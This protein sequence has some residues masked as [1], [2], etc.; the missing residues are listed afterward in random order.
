MTILVYLDYDVDRKVVRK[1]SLS[2]ARVGLELSQRLNTSLEGVVVNC[3][4]VVKQVA[5]LGIF[6]KIYDVKIEGLGE[7]VY[8][9]LVYANALVELC[10]RH[11]VEV[12]LFPSTLKSREIAPYVAAKL[13]TGIVADVSKL[14]VDE[15]GEVISVKPSFG[16]NILAH[17]SIPGRKPKIFT[18]RTYLEEVPQGRDKTHIETLVISLKQTP[19]LRTRSVTVED[20]DT[21]I[22]PE[23]SDIVIGIGAGVLPEN[24]KLLK[25]I[26]RRLK[27]SI[28]A[29]KKVTDRGILPDKFLVGESGKLIRPKL[30]IAL[31]ISGAPQHMTGVKESK[32]I[33]AVN[34]TDKAPIARQCDYFIR[35]DANEVIRLL[36]QRILT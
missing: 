21:A 31:G 33:V 1:E 15:K 26:A 35:A 18:V 23:R 17:I 19:L 4:A 20:P 10:A 24:V 29:T 22:L 25:E 30:Y 11:T 12:L 3:S 13:E 8:D 27:V 34:I 6:S 36:A 5:S 28:A 14:Y 32:I 16:E 2:L 9:P 7:G